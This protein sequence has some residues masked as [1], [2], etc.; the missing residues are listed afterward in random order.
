MSG[1]AETIGPAPADDAVVT[2]VARFI[3]GN[4]LGAIDGVG[5]H[6]R[7]EE[8]GLDSIAVTGLL[9]AVREEL[10]GS[11]GPPAAGILTEVPPLER[12]GDVAA[13]LRTLC[14]QGS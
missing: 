7:L 12:V 10:L 13:L 1:V 8:L 6:T 9:I 3:E 2:F 4:G 11:A 5:P 14:T